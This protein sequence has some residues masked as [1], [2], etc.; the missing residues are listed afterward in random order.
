MENVVYIL[1]AGFSAPRGLPVMKNFFDKAQ[2]LVNTDE[3]RFERMR[4]VIEQIYTTSSAGDNFSYDKFNIEEALSLLDIRDIL[5]GGHLRK[6]LE[7]FVIDVILKCTPLVPDL[8]EL[9]V[10]WKDQ[11]FG[12]DELQR[13]YLSFVA[14][15]NHLSVRVM[16]YSDHGDE[17]LMAEFDRPTD[18]SIRYDVI[19]LNY[20]TL[21]ED[22]CEY[23]NKYNSAVPLKVFRPGKK[24]ITLAFGDGLG[25]GRSL[26]DP[27]ANGNPLLLKIHGCAKRRDIILPTMIKGLG[28]AEIPPSWKI[29]FRILE[30]ATQIRILGYSLPETDAYIKD[31]LRSSTAN[32]KSISAIDVVCLDDG[33][34]R[35][36]YDRFMK[37]RNYRFA[38]A[39]VR[40]YMRLVYALRDEDMES[41]LVTFQGL[42][43]AHDDIM[44]THLKERH[45]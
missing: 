14:S 33:T 22:A 32:S 38:P 42:E 8:P 1:G 9:D 36:K 39:N 37:H 40:E 30:R 24:Q 3:K 44:K 25:E 35:E 23:L 27:A 26:A 28:H 21:L 16:N 45:N 31:L 17:R 5:T 11:L 15:L 4:D 13:G 29:A 7:D 2:E 43:K 41:K 34:V 19:T 18:D 20:D 12:A 6:E 10:G